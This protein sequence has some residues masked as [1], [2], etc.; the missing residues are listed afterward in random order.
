MAQGPART[1]IDAVLVVPSY[2]AVIV[3]LDADATALVI[4]LKLANE[5]P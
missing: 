5:A 2:V 4:T 1:G 3:A